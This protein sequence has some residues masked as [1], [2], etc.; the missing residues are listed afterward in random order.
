MNILSEK[1]VPDIEAKEILEKREKEGELKYE[2]KNALEL[3]KKFVKL[4][5]E[6]TNSLIEELAKIEKLRDRQI[7]SIVNFLPEDRDDLRAVL[8]KEY[9]ILTDEE[10]NLVLETVKKYS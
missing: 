5:K 7:V 8:Q 6:K 3:L 9:S 2:Q 4:D 10:I 1:T